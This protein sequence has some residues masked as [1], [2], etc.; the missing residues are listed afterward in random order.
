M[1]ADVCRTYVFSVSTDVNVLKTVGDVPVDDG[2]FSWRQRT[3]LARD[4]I[5]EMAR[6]MDV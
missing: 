2:P 4:E 3:V 5:N 6:S 1:V